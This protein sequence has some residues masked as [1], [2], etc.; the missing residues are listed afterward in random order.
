MRRAAAIA[1]MAV[2]LTGCGLMRG[3]TSSQPPIH[4]NPSMDDQPKLLAQAES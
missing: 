1:A 3:C 2:T 4:I